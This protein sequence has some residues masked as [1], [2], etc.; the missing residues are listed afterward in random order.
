MRMVSYYD[1]VTGLFNGDQV[2]VSDNAAIE[3]HTPAG[4]T[5]IDGHYDS[6]SQ[7]IDLATGQVV[8]YQPPPP[9][10]DHEWNVESKRWELSAAIATKQAA[11]SSALLAIGQLE[12]KGIRAM[13]E[14]ALSVPGAVDRLR[15]IDDQ[16]AALRADL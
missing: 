10:P 12:A 9:S 11:R 4:H 2:I 13:R 1:N 3:S 6:L 15:S 7:R 5:A 14:L 8:D 16:I